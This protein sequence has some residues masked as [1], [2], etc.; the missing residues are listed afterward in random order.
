VTGVE[1]AITDASP[2]AKAEEEGDAGRR[3]RDDDGDD[4]PIAMGG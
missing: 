4:E 3:E 2:M 1:T